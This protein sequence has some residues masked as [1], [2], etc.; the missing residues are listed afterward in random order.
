[1]LVKKVNANNEVRTWIKIQKVRYPYKYGK[2]IT[3][4]QMNDNFVLIPAEDV[5][6][7]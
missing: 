6:E 1:M 3:T 2:D 5:E 4:W 7:Q